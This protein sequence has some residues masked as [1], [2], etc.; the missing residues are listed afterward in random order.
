[1]TTLEKIEMDA[2]AALEKLSRGETPT[3]N[4]RVALDAY[5]LLHGKKAGNAGKRKTIKTGK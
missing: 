3:H 1:M 5:T 4:E 2:A